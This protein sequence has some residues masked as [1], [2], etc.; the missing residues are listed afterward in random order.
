MDFKMEF[1]EWE[2]HSEACPCSYGI[3]EVTVVVKVVV[4]HLI[5]DKYKCL[6]INSINIM[7]NVPLDPVVGMHSD[8][9]TRALIIHNHYISPAI[10]L[11]IP[12]LNCTD[13]KKKHE[14]FASRTICAQYPLVTRYSL[15]RRLVRQKV[16]PYRV[17]CTQT[18][19]SG[20][21]SFLLCYDLP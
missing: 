1:S 21:F 12:K 20:Q 18:T 19:F 9:V 4:N 8:E 2:G 11:F 15:H 16:C 13:Y 17:I 14:S 3:P 6:H 10:W 5:I 7:T